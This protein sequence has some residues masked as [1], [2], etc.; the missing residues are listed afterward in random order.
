MKRFLQILLFYAGIPIL[1]CLHCVVLI[2]GFLPVWTALIIIPGVTALLYALL[3]RLLPLRFAA[4]VNAVIFAA[5]SVCLLIVLCIGSGSLRSAAFR[6]GFRIIAFPFFVPF[7]FF[8]LTGNDLYG[9]ICV[10]AAYAAAMIACGCL[11][12]RCGKDRVE[13]DARPLWRKALPYLIAGAVFLICGAVSLTQYQNRPEV[14]YAGHGFAYMH[15]YSSTDFSD[16]T[17][18]SERSKLV[19][20]DHQPDLVIENEKDMPV[21]DGAEA[22]YPLY[23][24]LAK[25]VYRDIGKIEQN[26][27]QAD[28]NYTNGKIV[29]FTNTISGFIRLVEGEVD[30]FFGARPSEDQFDYAEKAGVPLTVTQIGREGFVFFVEADNPVDNLSSEQIRAIYHGDITNWKEVGGK[31]QKITAFQRPKDSGSQTM[32]EY[33][34]GDVS[35]ME[36][37]TYETIGSMEGVIRKVAQY[38]NEA[39]AMGYTFRYFL[40]GLQQEKGVKL[41]SVDGVAPTRENIENGSY[42]LTVGL[43]LVTRADDPNPNVQM[44]IDFILSEDGQEIVRRTGY[45]GVR[46][47]NHE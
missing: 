36:P 44:M 29:S 24:A 35:I 8:E 17:V 7:F 46:P 4:R 25:A 47:L 26:A 3:R 5:L 6:Y 23:A 18:Y 16:Y 22:C 27:A 43:C 28:D 19:E 20:L 12:K 38:A 13:N 45:A 14:R 1:A 31:N 15:G 33:F 9:V 21:M 10:F 32:M 11:S 41:L 34:M 42:P 40:E 2:F 30:L 37:K 39:G